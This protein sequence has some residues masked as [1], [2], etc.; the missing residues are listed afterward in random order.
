MKTRPPA[1]TT[2]DKERPLQLGTCLSRAVGLPKIPKE[3]LNKVLRWDTSREGRCFKRG[4]MVIARRGRVYNVACT[5]II[6]IPYSSGACHGE[7]RQIERANG[8]WG[9]AVW[10]NLVQEAWWWR[11]RHRGEGARNPLP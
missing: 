10:S 4:G 11:E 9:D 2:A 7:G 6:T 3:I 5:Q 1:F 8:S